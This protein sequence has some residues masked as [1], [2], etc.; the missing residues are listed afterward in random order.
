ML[1][2]LLG[3]F[4]IVMGTLFILRPQLLKNRILKKSYRTLRK[5]L[6]AL[7]VFLGILL[8]KV[9][10]EYEGLLSRV[11]LVIGV[12]AILKGFFIIKSKMADKMSEW[13]SNQRLIVFRIGAVVHILIGLALLNL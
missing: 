3:W 8:V 5:Y 12:I 2:K 13:F 11:I 1:A 10:F 4:F 6:F 7:S 9:S